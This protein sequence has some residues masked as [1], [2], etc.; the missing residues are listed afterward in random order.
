MLKKRTNKGFSGTYKATK[1][2]HVLYFHVLSTDF[3][4]YRCKSEK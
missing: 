2:Q 1:V 4:V 3:E